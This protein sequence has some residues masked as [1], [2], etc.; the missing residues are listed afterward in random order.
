MAFRFLSGLR[1]KLLNQSSLTQESTFD[2][3]TFFQSFFQKTAVNDAPAFVLDNDFVRLFNFGRIKTDNADAAISVGGENAQIFNFRTG[4]IE[5]NS[6]PDAQATAIDVTGSARI[7]NFGDIDGEFNAVSFSG[8]DSSG[9]LDNFRGGRITSDSRAVNIQGD[10]VQVRNFGEILGTDDQRNGTIYTDGSADNFSIRNF[11]RATIDAGKDNQGAGI[12]LQIGD[13]E[14]D[15]VSG[16]VTNSFRGTIQGRGQAAANS[17][18]AGDGI[19]ID[20]GAEN[21]TFDGKVVN[22]GLISSESTQ[23]TTAGIRVADG[24]NFDGSIVNTRTGVIEGPQNGLYVGLG[25]HDLDIRNSGTIRSDSR[26]LNIDGSGVDVVNSGKIIGT[27]DQRNG[28]VYADDTAT[29]YSITNQS[30]GLIDAGKGNDGAGISLSL[31]EDGNGDVEVTNDG[32]IIGRGQA[33]PAAGTAGDGIRLEG[34]RVD[35]GFGEALFDGTI[36]NSG[37]VISES[38]QGTVGAFRAVNNVNFQGTLTNERGGVFAGVQNGVYFGTGDHTGGQFLN[39]GLVT[40]DSRA[41][42]IDGD[43]LTV[44]N[45]GDILGTGDQ[46]NGTVYADGTADNYTLI[47]EASGRIDAGKGNDGSGVSLQTGDVLDDVV[48]ANVLNAGVIQGRGDAEVGNTI[49][50]GL[51]IFAGSDL[52]G[53]TSLAGTIINEGLIAGSEES[54]VA[55]GISVESGVDILGAILNEGE[56]RGLVNAIDARTGGSV[57]IVN[58]GVINGNVLLGNEGDTVLSSD[59]TINGLVDAGGGDDLVQTGDEDNVLIGGLGNDILDGGDGT[60]TARFDDLNVGVVADLESGIV[61]REGFAAD[62]AKQ[63]LINPNQGVTNQLAPADIVSEA[64]AGNLYFNVHTTAFPTGEVRGQLELV[65][66]VTNGHGVRTVTLT[67]ALDGDQEVPVPADTE[68]TGVGTV[69]FTVAE[70]GSV[71]Y[72]TDLDV[73]NLQG[74]LLPVN[75]GNGTL[76]PIHLHNAPAGQNGPV[77]VDVASDAGEGLVIV[78]EVD[79]LIDI[80]NLV[81]SGGDDVVLASEFA[82][83]DGVIDAGEGIDTVDFSSF[84]SGIAVDL[85]LNTPQ[86]GPASQD[87]ALVTQ[88]GPDG[89]VIQEFDNFENVVG[90]DFNDVIF[91]NNEINVLEGGDGND[92]IHSFGGPDILDGGDGID[93]ALF[94]AAPVGVTVDL[95]DD[96]NAVSSF[97]DTLIAFENIN[98]SVAGNDDISGNASANTLNGQGGNDRLAG[99]EGDDTLIGGAGEDVFVFALAGDDDTVNDFEDGLD[100]LDVTG[101]GPDFDVDAAIAGAVQD[102][103]D[104]LITLSANDSVRLVDFEVGNLNDEDFIA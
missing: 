48:S 94:S 85:D 103:D 24:V 28:T 62:V 51:R 86:P 12:S 83:V 47:N 61:T 45:E 69:I 5:A 2:G 102:G 57:N 9:Q 71:S 78:D 49:G 81:G 60:D 93:T 53:T 32:T 30:R 33:S 88:V 25:E 92:L 76:S 100:R 19:R 37:D 8:E 22:S 101:L 70:D 54:D 6:G 91:G 27:G 95:D 96:G 73:S 63:A 82:E 11:F 21:T 17:P 7:R 104:T 87:G 1:S 36:T 66:D 3:Q 4:S 16:L 43:G 46:R 74:D 38:A 23:G 10:G 41:V 40:S 97:G 55:A 31:A 42:N 13:E 52:D 18:L 20:N 14:G 58:D 26:A 56:I 67:A 35:G 59:G 77:V 65:S 75:I 80:E 39:E 50:N 34:V 29:D 90:T 99:E 84:S 89:D 79:T 98:G 44:V 64:V 15:V 72:E 68:A